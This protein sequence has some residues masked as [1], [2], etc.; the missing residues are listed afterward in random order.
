LT[1]VGL[2]ALL[3]I[4]MVLRLLLAAV[5]LGVR[6]LLRVMLSLPVRRRPRDIRR[7]ERRNQCNTEKTTTSHVTPPWSE[8]VNSTLLRRE[9]KPSVSARQRPN[10]RAAEFN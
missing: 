9:D 3:V 1:G 7:Q 10:A 4:R 5:V 6:T 2:A 8:T